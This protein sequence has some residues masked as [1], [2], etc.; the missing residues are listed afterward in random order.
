[1]VNG[2]EY[3]WEDVQVVIEGESTPQEGV[4]EI[5]YTTEKEHFEI[6]GRGEDPVKLGRGLKK[7]SGSVTVLQSLFEALQANVP[8]G[9]DITNLR[10]FNI[11]V[12]Y[13][14]EAG[15]A[16]TDQLTFCRIK[17]FEKGMK[18]EDGNMTIELELAIGKIFYN[19]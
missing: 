8:R 7:Y 13:A 5:K 2:F 11:T 4:T 18:T 16:T 15:A 1:M 19:I 6:H 3:S 9:R 14:P 10:P 12:S 17:K